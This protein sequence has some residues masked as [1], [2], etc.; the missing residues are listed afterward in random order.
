MQ[1]APSVAM[2]ILT[3]GRALVCRLLRPLF[4]L[5]LQ[6]STW[7]ETVAVVLR[8]VTLKNQEKD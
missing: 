4:D 7:H 3:G 1:R 6:P 5:K 8:R 2:G